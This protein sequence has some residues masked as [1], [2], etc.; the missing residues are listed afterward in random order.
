MNT[1]PDA[2]RE[3]FAYFL[4]KRIYKK[5]ARGHPF[6]VRL[7]RETDEYFLGC[8]QYPACRE[9][10]EIGFGCWRILENQWKRE[11]EKLNGKN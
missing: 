8:S 3:V 6:V 4:G 5:C 10:D 7:N 11:K 9:T 2:S 1:L